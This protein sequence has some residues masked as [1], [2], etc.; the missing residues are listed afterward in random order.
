MQVNYNEKLNGIEVSFDS[1]PSAKVL[2]NL[3]A[4]GFRW[5][6]VK[7]IW[8][9][10]DNAERRDALNQIASGNVSVS[11]SNGT[12]S[13]IANKCGVKVGDI[14]YFSFGYDMTIY[15]FFQ[16]VSVTENS[17]RVV[18]I[19][20][21]FLGY[22]SFYERFKVETGKKHAPKSNSIWIKNQTDGDVKRTQIPSWS[23]EVYL[24]F[25]NHYARLYDG[26]EVEENHWD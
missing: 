15:S 11:K 2:T 18:E 20:K 7:K 14:F 12:K 13:E 17:C 4:N 23:K 24:K 22:N 6:N 16:V 10:K 19:G 21:D 1:K 5:H 9:A 25:D 8:Y 3:K 26:R